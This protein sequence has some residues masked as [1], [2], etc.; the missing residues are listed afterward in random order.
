MLPS[1]RLAT[2][3]DQ[4]RRYQQQSCIYHTDPGP[5][6]LYTDHQCATGAFPSV[7]THILADHGDEVHNLAW[8]PDG[9]M[10]ATAGQDK[11]VVIW[12]LEVRA[13]TRTSNHVANDQ[14]ITKPGGIS[15][16]IKP[17]HQL[18]DHRESVGVLAWSPDG[19]TL[20]TAADRSLYLWDTKVDLDSVSTGNMCRKYS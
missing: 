3:L 5:S 16:D 9:S 11:M 14:E 2:L 18:R 13:R 17:L 4:A 20:V 7:T 12:S 8:S 19:A 1:R 15:Y 10:L 6:S